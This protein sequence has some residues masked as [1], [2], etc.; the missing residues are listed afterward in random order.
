MQV[1]GYTGTDI[2][3]ENFTFTVSGVDSNHLAITASDV[4]MTIDPTLP[5]KPYSFFVEWTE[6]STGVV[7]TILTGQFLIEQKD[8]NA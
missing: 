2:I 1:F 3:V 7:R 6:T 8:K 4:I 5:G